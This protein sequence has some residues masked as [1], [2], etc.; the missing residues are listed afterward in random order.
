[1][2]AAQLADTAL[3]LQRNTDLVNL[4]AAGLIT[5]EAFQAGQRQLAELASA[6]L[7]GEALGSQ[8]LRR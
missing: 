5:E 6:A 4:R 1:M 3:I 8:A 2:D 7:A